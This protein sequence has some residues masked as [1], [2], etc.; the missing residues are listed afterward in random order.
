MQ[1]ALELVSTA[2]RL[3][4][5]D[6]YTELISKVTRKIQDVENEEKAFFIDFFKQVKSFEGVDLSEIP[7][8]ET[9]FEHKV[10][11]KL[12][13]KY[14]KMIQFYTDNEKTEN[15][16]K[17]QKEMALAQSVL[18]RMNWI[19]GIN[20]RNPSAVMR[21]IAENMGIDLTGEKVRR[22]AER[23]KRMFIVKAFGAGTYSNSLVVHC[24]EEC[25]AEE[26]QRKE[27]VISEKDDDDDGGLAWK[28]GTLAF[29]LL[30]ALLYYYA[31]PAKPTSRLDLLLK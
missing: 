14:P 28:L 29:L 25:A 27:V 18:H 23:S 21:E 20:V 22:A 11:I 30:A 15:I 2:I 13:S 17:F 5:C 12:S 19:E 4:P 8:T 1:E 16:P 3:H 24:I 10:M 9:E 31:T 6:E 26:E 7:T